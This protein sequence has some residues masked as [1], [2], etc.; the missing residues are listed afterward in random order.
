MHEPRVGTRFARRIDCF[1][2]PLQ[3]ALRLR[4]RPFLF[5]VTCG[6]EK[7]NFRLDLFRL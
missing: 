4:E 1:L 3:H 5:R 2:P 7:K 6:R